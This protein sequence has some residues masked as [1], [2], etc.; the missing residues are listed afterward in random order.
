M[1]LFQRNS[2]WEDSVDTYIE[3]LPLRS[4]QLTSEAEEEEQEEDV[5]PDSNAS[6]PQRYRGSNIENAFFLNVVAQSKL[7]QR[8]KAFMSRTPLLSVRS[9]TQ[10]KA[11]YA[12]ISNDGLTI[13]EDPSELAQDDRD[14]L[15]TR[16]RHKGKRAASRKIST[17]YRD[18]GPSLRKSASVSPER[19]T[20]NES[21][22]GST[23]TD[24]IGVPT[25]DGRKL[26]EDLAPSSNSVIDVDEDSGKW[27]DE[28]P[29]DN[30]P[31][32]LKHFVPQILRCSNV[33]LFVSR[34]DGRPYT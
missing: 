21:A 2:S 26:F 25:G 34:L 6:F 24:D 11:S 1:T 31:S 19:Q 15:Q 13:E 23:L 17:T 18:P 29:P 27:R 28:N 9:S 4:R 7:L 32:V 20:P 22:P 5:S 33:P 10:S 14:S 16:Q 30:S 3:N 8:I 12:T